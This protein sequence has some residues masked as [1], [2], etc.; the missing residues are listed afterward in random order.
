MRPLLFAIVLLAGSLGLCAIPQQAL[1]ST[2]KTTTVTAKAPVKSSI[3]SFQEW[4]TEKIHAASLQVETSKA[5][6]RA[7]KAR[8]QG[9][10]GYASAVRSIE[11]QVTQERWNLEVAQDLS[12][13]DYLVLY[14]AHQGAPGKLAEAAVKLTPEETAQVLEAYIRN[15]GAFPAAESPKGLPDSASLTH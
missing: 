4:K 9:K 6:L 12:V 5:D 13:T 10:A 2:K 1:V 7:V 3:K 14:L 11:Q 8:A 15:M